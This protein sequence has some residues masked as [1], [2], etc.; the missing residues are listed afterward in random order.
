MNEYIPLDAEIASVMKSHCLDYMQA[1]A[2][3]ISRHNAF[4]RSA[5]TDVQVDDDPPPSRS[6]SV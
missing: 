2:Y 4:K 3:C 5:S 6:E 1:T